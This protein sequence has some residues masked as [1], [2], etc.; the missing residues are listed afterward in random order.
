[1]AMV[2][3]GAL[4]NSYI[5]AH[6][7][8]QSSALARWQPRAAYSKPWA[9][10]VAFQVTKSGREQQK[11]TMGPEGVLVYWCG[12]TDDNRVACPSKNFGRTQTHTPPME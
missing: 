12:A 6:S 2:P 8:D 3:D 9:A 4:A 5:S 11:N 7:L 1:M 10:E